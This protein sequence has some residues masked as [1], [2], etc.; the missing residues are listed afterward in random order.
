MPCRLAHQVI[1]ITETDYELVHGWWWSPDL[2]HSFLVACCSAGQRDSSDAGDF[3]ALR[4][5]L[6]LAEKISLQVR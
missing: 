3:L 1:L 6:D 4:N 2:A 5:F